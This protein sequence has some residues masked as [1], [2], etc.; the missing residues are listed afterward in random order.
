[1]T[2]SVVIPVL[3]EENN[4]PELA[5]RLRETLDDAGIPF[6]VVFVNDGSTDRT[7]Q[8]LQELHD[9]DKRIKAVHLARNFGHQGAISAGLAAACGGA[10]VIMDGD[11]QDPPEM[12]LR[13]VEKWREGFDVV[14]AIRERRSES[15]LK[16]Q[17]YKMF[18][19]LLGQISQIPMPLDTGD[20]SLMS[21]RVVDVL[22]AMP[23][24]TRFVRGMRSWVGFRQVGV[25]HTRG[26]R[27]AGEPKYTYGKLFRLALD[28]FFAFSYRPLQVASLFGVA[29]SVLAMLLATGLIVLKLTHGIPLL[30]WTSLIV[31]VFFMGG[32]QLI[33]VG[34][35]G[36]YVGRI[37][38]ETRG[39]PPYIVAR[40]TGDVRRIQ[41]ASEGPGE[42]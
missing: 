11:M 16:T 22:N 26:P 3:N 42:R 20:F 7:P 19:R 5:R 31:A 32:V 13:F 37:Y 25:G 28:G 35:L 36:E 6:E 10:V 30:G 39:R 24:R 38:E 23:E 15:W 27:Y 29:V 41:D 2:L 34:I 4:V 12:L 9:Q 33:C 18:Y 8:I 1:M 21:R 17:G 14:Y 40:V